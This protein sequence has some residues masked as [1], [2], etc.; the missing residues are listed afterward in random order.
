MSNSVY[1]DNVTFDTDGEVL[2][3][4]VVVDP[5][6]YHLPFDERSLADKRP[7][8]KII[9]LST[10]SGRD[11][12]FA[13]AF[14]GMSQSLIDADRVFP[15]LDRVDVK[16]NLYPSH[17]MKDVILIDPDGELSP[18]NEE[19]LQAAVRAER[20]IV[21]G[22]C[23]TSERTPSILRNAGAVVLG[24]GFGMSTKEIMRQSVAC[25]MDAMVSISN[26]PEE[27]RFS[28]LHYRL[29]HEA[30]ML[31]DKRQQQSRKAHFKMHEKKRVARG[32]SH[33]K[34]KHKGMQRFV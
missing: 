9:M 31:K 8:G 18:Q 1:P 17:E 23:H 11:D 21:M 25:M 7:G 24:I 6:E 33:A 22:D 26:Y 34:Q 4:C 16:G 32:R 15:V 12:A 10:P 2:L 14:S 19:A 3:P 5:D 30:T 28:D 13:A 27:F 20:V 29:S